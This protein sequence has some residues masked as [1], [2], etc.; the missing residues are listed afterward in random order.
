MIVFGRAVMGR[1]V[2]SAIGAVPV[3]VRTH[4]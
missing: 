4:A 2:V 3:H 1:F